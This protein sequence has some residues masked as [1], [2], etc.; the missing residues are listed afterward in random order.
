VLNLY[1]RSVII[2][3]DWKYEVTAMPDYQKLYTLLFNSIT[4]AIEL[5]ESYDFLAAKNVLVQAQQKAEDI[6]IGDD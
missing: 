3:A 2:F 6:Y 1:K 4:D 5:L